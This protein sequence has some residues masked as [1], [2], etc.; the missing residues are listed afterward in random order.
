[1]TLRTSQNKINKPVKKRW[2][3]SQNNWA[4]GKNAEK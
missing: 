4:E 2:D 3:K 1:M